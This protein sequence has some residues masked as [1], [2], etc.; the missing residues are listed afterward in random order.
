MLSRVQGFA[1]FYPNPK[2]LTEVG[3]APFLFFFFF[4]KS[5]DRVVQQLSDGDSVRAHNTTHIGGGRPDA[6]PVGRL[7]DHAADF[8]QI[9]VAVGQKEHGYTQAHRRRNGRLSDVPD[10]GHVVS[11]VR[12][13]VQ[14]PCMVNDPGCHYNGILKHRNLHR[15][16]R[17]V[18]RIQ[19]IIPPIDWRRQEE[20][21]IP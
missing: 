19:D 17:T 14:G 4:E 9:G 20:A 15:S 12:Q 11:K 13:C 7:C 16:T 10:Y 5:P 1:N 3:R 8:I 6:V 18:Y 21:Y 2:N